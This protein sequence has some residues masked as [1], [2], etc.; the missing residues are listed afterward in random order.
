[1]AGIIDRESYS[2]IHPGGLDTDTIVSDIQQIAREEIDSNIELNI[3][4]KT[5]KTDSDEYPLTTHD[6]ANAILYTMNKF[7][8]DYGADFSIESLSFDARAFF[9]IISDV[10][11]L[12]SER[13]IGEVINQF[14]KVGEPLNAVNAFVAD[15]N[16]HYNASIPDPQS[17][18]IEEAI[19][20]AIG[21]AMTTLQKNP[22]EILTSLWSGYYIKS[23]RTF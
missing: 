18:D 2:I 6:T 23:Y 3:S 14:S 1:M 15:L 21:T 8:Q 12:D 9:D 20:E 4:A 7:A 10:I 16:A 22:F 13:L 11:G 17:T 19:G 5:I